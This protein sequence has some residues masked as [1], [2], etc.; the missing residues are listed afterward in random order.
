MIKILFSQ[1]TSNM[2]YLIALLTDAV[3]CRYCPYF[4]FNFASHHVFNK[5]DHLRKISL[6]FYNPSSKQAHSQ[7]NYERKLAF[8]YL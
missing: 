7:G 6:C 3:D 5:V 4:L 2:M 8:F 1:S